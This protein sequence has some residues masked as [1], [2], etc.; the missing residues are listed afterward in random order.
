MQQ[1]FQHALR[2]DPDCSAAQRAL[3][4]LRAVTG[5]KERGNAA[6]SAGRYEEAYAAYSDSLEADPALRT[7]FVAQ[8]RRRFFGCAALQGGGC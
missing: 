3:K 6:F 8:V 4:R 1:C 7:A 5:G 2:R